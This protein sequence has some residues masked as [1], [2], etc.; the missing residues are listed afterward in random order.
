MYGVPHSTAPA[1]HDA[2]VESTAIGQ[3]R[4]APMLSEDAEDPHGVRIAVSL[5]AL[6]D[7]L[8][9]DQDQPEPKHQRFR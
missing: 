3:S 4:P 9:R 7:V 8:D 6:H 2:A 1:Q 5:C